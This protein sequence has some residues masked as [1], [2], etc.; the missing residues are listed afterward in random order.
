MFI[1]NE[2]LRWAGL[3]FLS[4][5][6][7][8]ALAIAL[9]I[10]RRSWIVGGALLIAIHAATQL[11][12]L[13]PLYPMD[14]V[15]PYLV[16]PPALAWVPADLLVVH[17][18][19]NYLFGPSTLREGR[20]PETH[21]RWLERRSF[22]ELYPFSGPV[23]GLRYELNT[24]PEGLDTYLARRAQ[25]E[26]QRA[27]NPERLKLLA[28]WGVGRLLI[29]HP[30]DPVPP[31]AKLLTRIPSFG[32]ELLVFE[33]TDRA[34][35]V[36][37]ARRVFHEKDIPAIYRRLAAPGFDPRTDAVIFG[38]GPS[39][40][41][42]GGGTARILRRGPE[43]YDIAV[44]AGPGGALLVVQRSNL[45]FSATIDGK[46]ADVRTA[47]AY[48]IGI[49][50]PAGQHRVRLYVDRAPLHR[51]LAA[52]LVGLLMVPGLGWWGRK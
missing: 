37:L 48:R 24:S 13:R 6:I 5:I 26:I 2:R 21:T 40:Q 34:P 52:A 19:Y 43:S 32:H 8:A 17:P 10:S 25:T 30:L 46:P 51:S 49:E 20:F 41:V 7:L 18:D 12:L 35:E 45:L 29:N 31:H 44:D 22:Y 16:P 42:T 1:A 27:K 39:P 28:A 11:W 14:A 38:T 4:L 23:W 15:Q 9:R 33:V 36:G 47:N 50:V 3:A